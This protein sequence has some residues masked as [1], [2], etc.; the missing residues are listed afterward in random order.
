MHPA[1]VLARLGG[2]A[3]LAAAPSPLRAEGG[4]LLFT[5]RPDARSIGECLAC[6][7]E[8]H[9]R[10]NHPVDVDYE[11]A[12]ARS[13]GSLREPREVVRA[14]V[15]LPGGRLHCLTCHDAR[16][17]WAARIA[18]PPGATPVP[19]VRPGPAAPPGPGWRAAARERAR[20]GSLPP[21]SA[22]SPAPLC[23]ACHALD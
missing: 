9:G 23:I 13:A 8:A 6:H 22:V 18:L 20:A 14:G 19:A 11:Q 10:G 12:A 7:A 21:G 16:S 4:C 2:L 17:P 15:F 3:L 1:S 5:A